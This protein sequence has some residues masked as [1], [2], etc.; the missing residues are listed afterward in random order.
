LDRTSF[1]RVA[2]IYD[3]TRALPDPV[4]R[5]AVASMGRALKGC[6]SVVDVGVGTGR[7]AKPLQDL[8]FRVSGVDVSRA[9]M[10]KASEKGVETLVLGDAQL[11]PIRDRAFDAAVA[12]HMLHLVKDWRTAARELGRVSR[13][14]VISLV[15]KTEGPSV[16]SEYFRMR[17][18]LGYPP[19]RLE[20]GEEGLRRA[21]R[22]ARVYRIKRYWSET[23][24]DDDLLYFGKRGSSITWDLD[25]RVH[26]EVMASLRTE[27]AGRTLRRRHTLELAV[28]WPKQLQP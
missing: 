2:G 23:K 13:R 18:Q 17:K 8:G 15:G 25:E 27:F 19:G 12:V 14:M 11:L 3:A 20:D 24:S 21:V 6:K 4:M 22:P 28:W 10:A 5:A 7:F 16:R 1:D 26:R 9:M